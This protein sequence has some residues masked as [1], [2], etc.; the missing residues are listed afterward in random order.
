MLDL[1]T[2]VLET[3]LRLLPP[4]L[5]AGFGG[6]ITQR[7]KLVNLGLEGFMLIGAFVA[8]VMSYFTGSALI[9]LLVTCFICGLMGLLFAIFNIKYKADN[10]VVSVAI[11]MFALGITK[12]FLNI[13]FGVRGAFSSPKIIG[14]ST[15]DLPFL[16]NIP[17]LSAFAHQS[18]ILYLS[19]LILIVLQITLFKTKIGLRIRA[20][21]PNSM[22]VQ[23]AGVNV[24]KLKC[25]VLTASGILC[26]IGGAYLSLGQ[27][28]MFTDNMTNGRGYVAMA[29][30]NFGNAMPV[31]TSLGALLFGFTDAVT[32]KAQ[33]YGFPPQLIQILPYLVTVLTLIGVGV[34]KKRKSKRRLIANE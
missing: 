26:G 6:L 1:I 2:S 7:I 31:G 3:T 16:E 22:A 34:Y 19:I 24:F 28:T 10:I 18:I 14:F 25:M 33:L 30:S 13:L 11:N 4:I 8:V 17:I 5:L 20:T 32:M 27:L 23:T 9:A 15:I 29:A 21:G 12:Y